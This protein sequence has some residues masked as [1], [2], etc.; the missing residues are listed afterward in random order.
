MPMPRSRTVVRIA[1][2][3]LVLALAGYAGAI[4]WAEQA[5]TFAT[6]P[7]ETV[8]QAPDGTAA[9]VTPYCT[10][11]TRAGAHTW[12]LGRDTPGFI[13]RQ[14]AGPQANWLSAQGV[15]RQPPE[16]DIRARDYSALWRLDADGS[17]RIAAAVT[18]SA[19]LA[20]T[21]DDA[22]LFLLSTLDSAALRAQHG[23][24]PGVRQTLVFRSDDGGASWQ[25]Q[26]QGLFAQAAL[27]ASHQ[28]I[29]WIDAQRAW[30]VHD[31]Q[32]MR[33]DDRRK[34]PA[35]FPTGWY[36]SEDQ[37]RTATQVYS[38]TSLFPAP[39]DF[40]PAL[41][42]AR[43]FD[44][45]YDSDQSHLAVLDPDRALGWY[46]HWIG[47]QSAQGRAI[48]YLTTQVLL[49]RQGQDW[50][51]AGITRQRG[52]RIAQIAQAPNGAIHAVLTRAGG[53]ATLARLDPATLEWTDERPLPRVFPLGL[54]A[55]QS[56]TALRVSNQAQV[57]SLWADHTVPRL[58]Y[59]WGD[60]PA[61][62]SATGEF[63]TA[64][65]GR[66]WRRLPQRSPDDL[67]GMD[68]ARNVLFWPGDDGKTISG[69]QLAQ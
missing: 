52:V 49:L 67:L 42:N 65:G 15:A 8:G 12:M 7:V 27:V 54:P 2:A 25:W 4:L 34:T 61:S 48:A 55:Y 24:Q 51:I 35:G 21:P 46:T 20:V 10:G 29:H 14:N 1:A 64:D 38:E 63:W 60:A 37:G 17:F 16:R 30:S 39:A 41:R 66:S 31:I 40:G 45:G 43:L 44:P 57:V 18:D 59:P 28:D 36:Y 19:C 22:S 6:P 32:D 26:E 11:I 3:V 56:V 9:A 47:Y 23:T 62:I 69:Y 5:W 13:A 50:R 58:L 33:E 68:G 53:N